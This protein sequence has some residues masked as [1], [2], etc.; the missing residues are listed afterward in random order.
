MIV[1]ERSYSQ[2]SDFQQGGL[3]TVS[4]ICWCSGKGVVDLNPKN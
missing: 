1:M 2:G 4:C 3:A